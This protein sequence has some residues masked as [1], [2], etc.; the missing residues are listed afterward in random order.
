MQGELI[1]IDT[2]SRKK[3]NERPKMFGTPLKS[4]IF[5]KRKGLATGLFLN[6]YMS[7]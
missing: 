5:T 2:G 1:Q 6:I 3:E 7:Y 4:E